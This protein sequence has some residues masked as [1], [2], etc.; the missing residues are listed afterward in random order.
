L[1]FVSEHIKQ[2]AEQN[3]PGCASQVRRSH[4]VPNGVD[5]DR[6]ALNSKSPGKNVAFLGQVN[7]KKGP[8]LLYQAARALVESDPEVEVFI[9]GEFVQPHYVLYFVHHLKDYEHKDRIHLEGH[10]DDVP[11]WLKKMDF[12]LCTSVLEGHPVGIMEAMAC[13]LTP[14]IHAFY[15]A[16]TL[17]PEPYLWRSLDELV[18]MVS[19][20]PRPPADNRAFIEDGFQLS[21]Q[22]EAIRKILET[23][24]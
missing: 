1:I 8:M 13:G 20:G 11:G 6:F 4:V 22:I 24:A 23:P 5:L 10:V 16:A 2:I 18:E 19:A 17:Y 7:F 15:G 12:I 14:L 3:F 9:A 21:G